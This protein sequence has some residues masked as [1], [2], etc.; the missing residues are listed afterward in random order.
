MT[1]TQ[2]RYLKIENEIL[3]SELP[4]R[5]TVT[6][7]ERNK[8]ME[9]GSKLGKAL[10]ELVS[11]VHPD[12]LRRWRIGGSRGGCGRRLETGGTSELSQHQPQHG[13]DESQIHRND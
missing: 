10:G 13:K 1:I 8:L 9:F 12:T 5:V 11:I 4:K 3:R 6:D 2:I 7:A